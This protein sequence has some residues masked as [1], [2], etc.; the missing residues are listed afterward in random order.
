VHVGDAMLSEMLSQLL[1]AYTIEYDD[2]FEHHLPHRTA[3]Y[4]AGGPERVVSSSGVPVGKPWL[5][6][7]A[8]WSNFMRYVTPEGV[9]LGA[10]QG[11]PANLAG[12]QRWGYIVVRPPGPDGGADQ[13]RKSSE[14]GAA[15][16]KADWL[17]K[18]TRAGRLAQAGWR[19]LDGVIDRR[20]EQR[21][22]ARVVGQ[23]RESLRVIAGQIG[24]GL[25]LYL[26]VVGYAD[27]MRSGDYREVVRGLPE[28]LPALVELDLSALMSAVLLAFT[29]EYEA[30]SKLSLPISANTLRVVGDDGVR[31]SDIPLLA[32]VSREG[33][34]SSL[35]FL[36][37]H[38]YVEIGPDPSG[39]RGKFVR[40]TERGRRARDGR[41]RLAAR[42]ESG[43]VERFGAG[44]VDR[45]RGALDEMRHSRTDGR[46]TLALGLGR[47]PDG[48]R[49]RAPYLAQTKAML[50]DPAQA[51]PRHPMVLH[52]GGYP[53]GC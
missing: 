31:V 13:D 33:V 27:G 53:D 35:G 43:W 7:M 24:A 48:W 30:T 8:M 47:Y 10:V 20:W 32:G 45:L 21:F 6:L 36:E 3:S 26:P 9:P 22:G 44:E 25:P 38:D 28:P 11:M 40:P 52:R 51:L 50:R 16:P 2:E 34:S 14:S 23:L 18:A 1:V 5:C 19:R 46:P 4:G 17:V 12:L 42:V 29:L 15:R 39:R 41:R 37:R 49:S